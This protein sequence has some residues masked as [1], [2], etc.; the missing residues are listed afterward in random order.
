MHILVKFGQNVLFLHF[1]GTQSPA[2]QK[3]HFLF[4][5]TFTP[6]ILHFFAEKISF[7]TSKNALFST[8]IPKTPKA[9]RSI[10]RISI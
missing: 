4:L 3:P 9:T 5:H 6:P 7:V 8:G 1:G 10:A 2:P